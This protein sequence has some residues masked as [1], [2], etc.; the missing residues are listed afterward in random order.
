MSFKIIVLDSF[1]Q[2]FKKLQKKYRNIKED[3]KKLSLE[4]Q[5]NPRAGIALQHNCYKIRVA[6]SSVPTGKSGGFRTIYYC[7]DE[8]EKIYL[9]A[10]YSK[11]QRGNISDNELIELLKINGLDM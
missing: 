2:N 4:L 6:N 11:T 3:I 9:M 10:I 1:K 5:K 8:E 7:I